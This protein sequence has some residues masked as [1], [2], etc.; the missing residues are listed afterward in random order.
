MAGSAP[1]LN[2]QGERVNVTAV[3]GRD[4]AITVVAN[5]SDTPGA[6]D[7]TGLTAVTMSGNTVRE[8]FVVTPVETG[9][10]LLS[11][12]AA[13]TVDAGN[14]WVMTI[15]GI[16]REVGG[17]LTWVTRPN[18]IIR[19]DSSSVGPDTIITAISD[20]DAVISLSL[21]SVEFDSS[22][23]PRV[24]ALETDLAAETAARIAADD[25][26]QADIDQNESDSDAADSVL[27]TNI[28]DEEAARIAADGALQTDIDDEEAARIAAVAAV[29]SDVDQN[30]ADSD[31]ADAALQSN[32]DDET[33][34]RIA[35]DDA[36]DGRLT[37][38]EAEIAALEQGLR[39][40]GDWDA[41]SG[42]F[43]TSTDTGE[44]WIVSVAG[45][46]DSVDFA[47]GDMV[48][49]I[50]DG[51]S[52][53]VYAGNWQKLDNTEQVTQ[54]ELDAETAARIAADSALSDR[55]D[56]LE[57]DPTTATAVAAVASDLADH[58]ALTDGAHGITPYAASLV[59]DAD[60]AEAR[61]TL[62]VLSEDEVQPALDS[63][64]RYKALELLSR[65]TAWFAGD[66]SG[67]DLP[68]RT[69]DLPATLNGLTKVD[70][71]F[72]RHGTGAGNGFPI[73]AGTPTA[74]EEIDWRVEFNAIETTAATRR[75][76]SGGNSWF[77]VNPS[78]QI[79]NGIIR[80]TT[81]GPA[82]SGNGSYGSYV[83]ADGWVQLRTYWDDIAEEVV[84]QAR[85][86][87]TALDVDTGWT[88][89]ASTAYAGDQTSGATTAQY[90]MQA[91]FLGDFAFRGFWQKY[92][93]EIRSVDV[94]TIAAM[95]ADDDTLTMNTQSGT[96]TTPI[97]RSTSGL[98][99]Q[100]VPRGS[101]LVNSD[102]T[103][104]ANRGATSSDFA[105]VA[106]EEDLILVWAGHLGSRNAAYGYYLTTTFNTS[107]PN[108]F[109]LFQHNSLETLN[110]RIWPASGTDVDDVAIPTRTGRVLHVGVV[111]R[112]TQLV[113]TYVVGEDGVLTAGDGVAINDL[114][115]DPI[116]SVAPLYIGSGAELTYAAA[117]GVGIGL[118]D[119]IDDDT[120]VELHKLIAKQ[121][122]TDV[123]ALSPVLG[124][125][126][127]TER[128]RVAGA[129]QTTGDTFTGAVNVPVPTQDAHAARLDTVQESQG[130]PTY[131]QDT[132]PS[133]PTDGESWLDT[134][135]MTLYR[136]YDGVWVEQPNGGLVQVDGSELNLGT[137][138]AEDAA[139][140]AAL[141][142]ATFTG[143]L[144]IDKATPVLS[145]DADTGTIPAMRFRQNGVT[146]WQ[147]YLQSSPE[148]LILRRYDAV[149][150]GLDNPMLF[151]GD[152]LELADCSAV[153]VPAPTAATHAAR[154]DTYTAA[155]GRIVIAG[156]EVGSTG[157]RDI[158]ATVLNSFTAD[159]TYKILLIRY[160]N[161]VNIAA[162]VA[163][164][165]SQTTWVA[166]PTGFRPGSPPY[167]TLQACS[168]T[169]H[170]FIRCAFGGAG[171]I[172]FAPSPS[173]GT[174]IDVFGSW[175]TNDAWPSSLPGTQVTAPA[176][177]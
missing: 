169:A 177:L 21:S 136:R 38:A 18:T 95:A 86:P 16:D 105:A 22:L 151:N 103:T 59:D 79:A 42:S 125:L 31:A 153:I 147:W 102:P 49:A 63:T 132:P 39:I 96:T 142:G 118:A 117:V 3:R 82:V 129:A 26:L 33:A 119:L 64:A 13:D 104:T 56:P 12:A 157:T 135:D 121:E 15:P 37:T 5:D 164:P 69:A 133:S 143:D 7:L 68:S 98:T 76:G 34:A 113:T 89:I 115:D 116:L 122:W 48:V 93:S 57:A 8:T 162:R 28:D 35:A 123:E 24:D 46:V 154:V 145:I 111:S 172:S 148:R 131:E 52:T 92:G 51:A 25:A 166:V 80:L 159:A 138:A 176:T 75:I 66:A 152:Q 14:E 100:I 87:G 171:T 11:I 32:I 156:Q 141:T 81:A 36:L 167:P 74:G 6:Y 47:P 83:S 150:G 43:P 29:Q 165:G 30:E 128:D 27:Q 70:G 20:G 91:G 61:D 130:R 44:T 90:M 126:T 107:T 1:H 137:M 84:L 144:T 139:D 149:G 10:V 50:T 99:F 101:V 72:F 146:R 170:T 140:Y 112:T 158:S 97:T 120:L 55:L 9:K 110:A 161:T 62:E 168:A 23:P 163:A 109:A 19:S 106:G 88:T 160:G 2:Q 134:R 54:A 4:L 40:M 78:S 173:V 108:T 53:T 41:S 73:W 45:T 60:A 124:G 174:L 17:K 155:T 94:A 77:N 65:T 71:P 85:A 58:E 114:G 127:P 175:H 67:S